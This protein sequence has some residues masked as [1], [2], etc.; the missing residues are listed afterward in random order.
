MAFAELMREK[1]KEKRKKL[2]FP[3]GTEPRTLKAA[4]IIKDENIATEVFLIGKN[5]KINEAAKNEKVNMDGITI[6]DPDFSDLLTD[7]TR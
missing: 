6:I 3:E 4:R 7:Y 1:A 5:D 2:V